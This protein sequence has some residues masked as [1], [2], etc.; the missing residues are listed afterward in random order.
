MSKLQAL[1]FVAALGFA[2][3]GADAAIL[4]PDAALCRSGDAPAILVHIVGLK[5]REG[6]VRVRSFGGNPESWFNKKTYLKRTEIATPASGTVDICMPVPRPGV[7][8]VDVRHDVNGNGDTD[9][10]D[11]GGASGNPEV[12]LFDVV[13]N[14]KPPASKT[15]FQVGT[16][17]TS[18]TVIV[19]YKQGGSFKPIAQLQTTRR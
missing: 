16:G 2:A 13:F 11:G 14:R 18:V 6:A 1:F 7:Y 19:K 4:G 17:V 3:N 8:A 15:G 9:M 10:A 12:S 5:N